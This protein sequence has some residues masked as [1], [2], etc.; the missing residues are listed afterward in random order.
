MVAPR[1]PDP[2]GPAVQA[3]ALVT[4]E[5]LIQEVESSVITLVDAHNG[6]NELSRLAM[7]W[8]VRH[9]WLAGQGLC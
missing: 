2:L 3:T 7:L 9:R 4:L 8:T 1:S 5:F 6:S